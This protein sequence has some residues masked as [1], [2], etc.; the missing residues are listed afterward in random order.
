MQL[1]EFQQD[2][3]VD[4]SADT[5]EGE[6]EQP[7]PSI[8]ASISGSP[9]IQ[10][11]PPAYD[12]SAERNLPPMYRGKIKVHSPLLP[13]PQPSKVEEQ[14]TRLPSPVHATTPSAAEGPQSP[15]CSSSTRVSP[16]RP[17]H[18]PKHKPEPSSMDVD[19]ELL[20]LIEDRPSHHKVSCPKP[21]P[22][23]SPQRPSPPDDE[24][25]PP[26]PAAPTKKK[27][28]PAKAGKKKGMT[29][30]KV[31]FYLIL[32]FSDDSFS[33]HSPLRNPNLHRK[34]AQ[35]LLLRQKPRNL[36]R[37]MFSRIVSLRS[38]LLPHGHALR[39]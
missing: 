6:D 4:M 27:A 16:A 36:R 9:A 10:A 20:S 13:L 15:L 17:S 14:E 24:L 1:D 37:K 29:A 5:V 33:C 21:K 34:R 8:P 25:M 30:P 38:T 12:D 26:P 35:N 18:S 3:D 32:R 31:T 11:S 19:E 39:L 23:P 7:Q 2:E 22:S 28:E